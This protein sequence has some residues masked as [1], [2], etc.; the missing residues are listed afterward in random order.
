MSRVHKLI[1]KLGPQVGPQ[2]ESTNWVHKLGQR[3]RFTSRVH[4]LGREVW[5]GGLGGEGEGGN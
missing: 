1:H 5:E 3:F 2:A 4:E